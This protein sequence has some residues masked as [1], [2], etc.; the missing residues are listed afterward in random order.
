MHRRACTPTCGG[1]KRCCCNR[2]DPSDVCRQQPSSHLHNTA[3]K[4]DRTDGPQTKIKSRSRHG[5][6]SVPPRTGGVS[7][8]QRRGGTKS[9]SVQIVDSRPSEPWASM[10][11]RRS[12]FHEFG[13]VGG[14]ASEVDAMIPPQSPLTPSPLAQA[15]SL[16]AWRSRW[17]RFNKR[18]SGRSQ[19]SSNKVATDRRWQ[20]ANQ[21]HQK[22]P[23]SLG[24]QRSQGQQLQEISE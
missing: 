22:W 18:S 21:P 3:S 10:L 20:R 2:A 1:F 5:R 16:N 12:S 4:V 17:A 19:P 23:D 15:R 9:A 14:T 8:N 24:S 7:V 6:V 11:P 13:S